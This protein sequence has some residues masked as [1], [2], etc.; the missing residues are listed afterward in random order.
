MTTPLAYVAVS[1]AEQRARIVGDLRQQGWTVVEQPTG[2]HL[3]SALAEVIDGT[4]RELPAKIIIDAHARG[5]TG[6]SIAAGLAALGLSI[7]VEL[8]EGPPGTRSPPLPP[9]APAA[10]AAA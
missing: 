5:C 2:F 7:P 9:G 1:N 4:A 3:I 10:F 8:V 6:K